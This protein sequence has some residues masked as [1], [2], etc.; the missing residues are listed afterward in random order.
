VEDRLYRSRDERVVAGVCGGLAERYDLDPS[1]VRVAW[2][3][4]GILT[5]VVPLV[6]LYFLIA[7]VVPE[8][9]TGLLGSMSV[10]PPAGSPA[11]AAWDA[12]QAAERAARRSARRAERAR[13]GDDRT[14]A[15]VV[16]VVLIAI[17]GAFLLE[18]WF[19]VDWGIVWPAGIVVIGI[20]VI[21]GSLRR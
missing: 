19:R 1:I 16:G 6:L 20:L 2:V 5:G 11:A 10:N 18:H 8:E 7:I 3:V 21:A 13:R 14:L 15:A 4:V 17:G 9:P 12:A